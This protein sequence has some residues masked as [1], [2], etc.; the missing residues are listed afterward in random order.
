AASFGTLFAKALGHIAGVQVRTI[1]SVGGSVAGRYG[2]SELLVLLLALDA[3]VSLYRE[4][5]TP[6]SAFLQSPRGKPFL[7]EKILVAPG[8]SAGF[9]S[10]RAA[11]NDFSL[12]S[13]C[14]SSRESGWRVAVGARPQVAALGENAGAWLGLQPKPGDAA[15]ARAGELAA[16]ELRF[17][18]DVRAGAA[19]RQA[20]C[21]VLVARAVMEA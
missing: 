7:L 13:V 15:A 8:A 3:R 6:L 4:G 1:V 5:E 12:L 19:Y 21:P 18:D 9:Q 10:L 14:A 17:G 20:V 11:N 2:F 16:Q